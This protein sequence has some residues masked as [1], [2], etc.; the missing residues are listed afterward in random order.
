MDYIK[1]SN[2][3]IAKVNTLWDAA[4]LVDSYL[5]MLNHQYSI[6]R[7]WKFKCGV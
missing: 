6:N 7:L 2:E 3:F 5:Y 1:H 4:D